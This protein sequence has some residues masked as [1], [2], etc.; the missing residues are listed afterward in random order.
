[1]VCS[2]F[3]YDGSNIVIEPN[4]MFKAVIKN[5]MYNKKLPEPYKIRTGINELY[6]AIKCIP[7]SFFKQIQKF[8]N[9][10]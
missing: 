3:S 1:M 5:S 8:L 9:K 10:D 4:P 7:N 6:Q 2:N